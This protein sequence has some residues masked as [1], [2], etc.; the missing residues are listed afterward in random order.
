[1]Y[2]A[3]ILFLVSS[4]HFNLA[5]KQQQIAGTQLKGTQLFSVCPGMPQLCFCGADILLLLLDAALGGNMAFA[6]Q[7]AIDTEL[8]R[9]IIPCC[10]YP[11]QI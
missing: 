10:D 1:M 8:Y 5:F 7:L 9:G 2:E 11:K 4:F 3:C 6:I